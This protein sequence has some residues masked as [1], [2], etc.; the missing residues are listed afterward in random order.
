MGYKENFKHPDI[1]KAIEKVINVANKYGKPWGMPAAT[2]E[3]FKTRINQGE[4]LLISGSNSGLVS[5]AACEKVKQCRN[6]I[7]NCMS[8]K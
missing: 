7:E 3:D 8:E 5:L 2:I 1:Q 6:V 4:L